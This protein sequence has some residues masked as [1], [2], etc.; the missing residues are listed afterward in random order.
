MPCVPEAF[1]HY[2][3]HFIFSSFF[4]LR[5]YVS[6]SWSR[7]KKRA[8]FFRSSSTSKDSKGSEDTA[9]CRYYIQ[10]TKETEKNA[11]PFN[12][13]RIQKKFNS[14]LRG[15]VVNKENTPKK[16]PPSLLREGVVEEVW[17]LAVIFLFLLFQKVFF[18][19]LPLPFSSV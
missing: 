8:T 18:S 5:D 7:Q 3:L 10:N 13:K 11:P 2:Q 9:Q 12:K 1:L 16:T 4:T 6:G 14:P 17:R 19:Q 15:R